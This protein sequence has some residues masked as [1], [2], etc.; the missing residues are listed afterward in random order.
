MQVDPIKPMLKA[1]KTKRLR[2][3][4][5]ALLSSFAFKF[6]LRRYNEDLRSEAESTRSTVSRTVALTG[7]GSTSSRTIAG[8]VRQGA[9]DQSAGAADRSNADRRPL[10]QRF[11]EGAHG[12][13]RASPSPSGPFNKVG[14]GGGGGGSVTPLSGTFSG[15]F[16]PRDSH[17]SVPA[18]VTP[19]QLVSSSSIPAG[20]TPGVYTGGHNTARLRPPSAGR[21][22]PRANANKFKGAR[23]GGVGLLAGAHTRSLLGST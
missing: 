20:V 17:S 15:T 6:N 5:D 8:A 19:R 18:G 22:M 12:R 14:G 1:P 21:K 2:P 4:C 3:K 10:S 23:A 7:T 9:A 11:N 16:T 13:G